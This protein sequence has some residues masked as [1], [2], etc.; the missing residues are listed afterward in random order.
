MDFVF[1]WKD[2]STDDGPNTQIRK[3]PARGLTKWALNMEDYLPLP[4][5]TSRDG[6][7]TPERLELH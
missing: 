4:T 2:T 6:N 5:F 1:S 7:S 3:G